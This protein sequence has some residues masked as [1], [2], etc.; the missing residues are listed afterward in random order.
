MSQ[1]KKAEAECLEEYFF[2]QEALM[3]ELLT[4]LQ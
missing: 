3:Y 2:E 1:N 4:E